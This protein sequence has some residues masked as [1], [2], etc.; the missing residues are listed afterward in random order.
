MIEERGHILEVLKGVNSALKTKDAGLIS[1]LS[2]QIIHH[3]SVH[4]D[5][6]VISVAVIIYSLS[7][8]VERED[9][10]KYSN[11]EPFY[12]S[13][14][15]GIQKAIVYLENEQ[16]DKFRKEIKKLREKI[17]QISG[18]LKTY[19]QDVFTKAQIN[20]ASKIYE[21]GISMEQTAKILGVT[22]WELSEYAGQKQQET[23]F[24]TT[25]PIRQRIKIVEEVFEE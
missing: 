12:K 22:V 3:S 14:I 20:K 4:Q 11:W 13:Y 15:Q 24:T 9:L 21:H 25:M 19:I 7:K 2:N 8:L 16:I 6:D 23:G 18:K 1:Q 10:K 17:G 5:P